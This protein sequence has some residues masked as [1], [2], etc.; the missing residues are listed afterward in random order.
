MVK[1]IVKSYDL[2]KAHCLV[3]ISFYG[4]TY[5]IVME[6]KGKIVTF[7]SILLNQQFLFNRYPFCSTVACNNYCHS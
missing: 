3:A 4:V 2:T 1:S 7:V 5:N 6:V